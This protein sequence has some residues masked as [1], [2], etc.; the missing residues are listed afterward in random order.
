MQPCTTC[1]APFGPSTPSSWALPTSPLWSYLKPSPPK[2]IGTG[3]INHFRR[4][5]SC[6]LSSISLTAWITGRLF[7]TMQTALQIPFPRWR[8][9]S[10]RGCTGTL[11]LALQS[12][13]MTMWPNWLSWEGPAQHSLARVPVPSQ[14]R[15]NKL[16]I[17]WC[18][19]SLMPLR[20]VK[21]MWHS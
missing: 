16:E 14:S 19:P 5:Y 18:T 4:Q 6:W 7:S 20:A 8:W 10:T 3:A 12:R 1:Q 11:N 2:W 15:C 13:T 17:F 21:R 9:P